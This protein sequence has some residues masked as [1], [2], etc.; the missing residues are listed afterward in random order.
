MKFF[1]SLALCAVLSSA[2]DPVLGWIQ[3]SSLGRSKGLQQQQHPAFQYCG[4]QRP[5]RLFGILDDFSPAEDAPETDSTDDSNNNSAFD[6]LLNDLVFSSGDPHTDI[7]E[8][9]EECSDPAFGEWLTSQK[10]ASNDKEER[11][12]LQELLGMIQEVASMKLEQAETSAAH[13]KQQSTS[14]A[15]EQEDSDTTSTPTN[16]ISDQNLS[17]ADLLKKANAIDHAVMTSAGAEDPDRPSDF[18]TDAKAER[19]LGGF[20]NSGRMRV[21]GG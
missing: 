12:A 13:Q 10:N 15:T 4:R 21:G 9:W 5:T 19:G 2:I 17:A 8:R 18:M 16:T 3:P 7:A 1:H 14:E 6:D 20:N 11:E